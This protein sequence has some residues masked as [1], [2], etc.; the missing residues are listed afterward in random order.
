MPIF[1]ILFLLVFKPVFAAEPAHG[2]AIYDAPKYPAD[3]THF[4][5]VNAG[6]PKGGT[7][8]FSAPETFDSFNGFISKGVAAV[9]TDLLYP[10]LMTR[11]QDEVFT[12]YG[13]LANT[14]QVRN[15][16]VIFTLRED[17]QWHDGTP[18]TADD[19]VWTFNT[20]IEQGRPAYRAYYGDVTGVRADGD[21][22]VI[23]T[24]DNLDNREL[25]LI[26]GELPVL[27]K[28]YWTSGARDFSKTTLE[29]P[30]GGGPYK[31]ESFEQGRSVTYARVADWW[32]TDLPVYKGRYNFDRVVY[33]YYRDQDVSLQAFF[34]GEFDIRREYTAKLWAT[35]YGVPAVQDGR[36]IKA[37]IPNKLPQGMQG[38]AMNLRRPVFADIA[39]RKAMNLAFDFEWSNKQFAFNAYT[40]TDSYFENSDMQAAGT[41][42][43]EAELALLEPFRDQLPSVVFETAPSIP[44]SDGSG[45]NRKALRAAAKLLDAAGFTVGDDGIRVGADGTRLEFEFLVANTNAAFERWFGPY[46]KALLRLGIDGTI[47]IV[48]ASQYVQKLLDYE[49]DLIVHSWGQSLS[50]GNEQREYW[51][52]DRALVSGTRNYIGLQDPVVDALVEQVIAAPSRDA[53]VTRVRALD[54]VLMHGHYVVP[55]WH[56]AGWRIAHWDH[57]GKPSVQADYDLGILDTWW[58]KAP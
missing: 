30:L 7:I 29:P 17:A 9:G 31:L 32:G 8:R 2:I 56:I 28:H 23:F 50:P 41:L 43:G 22:R 26:L 14:V 34:A 35:G 18:I 44:A 57:F 52:S 33:Q 58:S 53:L 38:F 51:K 37:Y 55:N 25:P 3:F 11:A 47:R 21:R 36:I 27:P 6:A 5:Y 16:Q 10:R 12:M 49:F 42:P 15:G 1:F 40:R 48:D 4:A 54:R 13:A 46:K 45:N 39:V 19:V 20:L 24:Y